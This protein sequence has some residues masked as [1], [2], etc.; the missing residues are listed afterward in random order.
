LLPVINW[1]LQ[2]RQRSSDSEPQ[3]SRPLPEAR[4]PRQQTAARVATP[5]ATAERLTM[6]QT[7]PS[8]PDFWRRQQRRRLVPRT[9]EG[10]QHAIILMTILG[11]CRA[12]EPP[13]ERT[14]YPST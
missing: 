14:S 8:A 1:F 9:K 4:R 12:L 3:P 11:P 10:L 7:T 5:Q 13:R 2:R 6:P